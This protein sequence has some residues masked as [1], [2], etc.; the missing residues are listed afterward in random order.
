[1]NAVSK[2]GE[3]PL[4]LLC[5]TYKNKGNNLIQLVQLLIDNGADINRPNMDFKWKLGWTSLH[6][7]I[8]NSNNVS[9]MS[10]VVKVFI[11]KGA[12]VNAKTTVT[13]EEYT[14]LYLLAMN[15]RKYDL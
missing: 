10:D 7:L 3:I 15:Y 11:E 13:G 6:Y 4:H 14:P 2:D 9:N 12:N 5:K 8:K 1:M